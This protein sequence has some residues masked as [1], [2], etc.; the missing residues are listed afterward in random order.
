[1]DDNMI[2]ELWELGV[3]ELVDEDLEDD[4]DAPDDELDME[5]GFEAWCHPA[6]PG[7]E[8]EG[9]NYRRSTAASSESAR[10]CA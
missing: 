6:R 8:I 2:G 7:G 3:R 1:M 4:A 9:R 5:G 10:A